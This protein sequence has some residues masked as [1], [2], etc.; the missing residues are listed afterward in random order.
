MKY[1]ISTITFLFIC[2]IFGSCK[3]DYIRYT[4]IDVRTPA[5]LTLDYKAKNVLLVDNSPASMDS[6]GQDT[7]YLIMPDTARLFILGSLHDYINNEEVFDSVRFYTMNLNGGHNVE[8]LSP[9]QIQ[10]LC[11]ESKSDI[12]ISFDLI[13]LLIP[14]G[15]EYLTRKHQPPIKGYT[16]AVV[17]IYRKDG[18]PIHKTFFFTHT[19]WGIQT[20]TWRDM[21]NNI[22]NR[23]GLL[24]HELS[25]WSDKMT[26][27][28]VP[29]WSREERIYY[30][31]QKEY[32]KT[33]T[34]HAQKGEWLEAA[35]IW[36]Q[37]YETEKKTAEKVRLAANIA[38]ANEYLDDLEYAKEWIT[39]AHSLLEE[40]DD[41]YLAN[42]VRMYK[43]Q[44]ERRMVK[45]SE[46]KEQLQLI[47][48]TE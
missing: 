13:G 15:K 32:F 5:E 28:L 1:I 34:Q 33:A 25:R 3:T 29:C 8:F 14:R 22:Y 35:D 38:L 23:K 17:N 4:Y 41:S 2:F 39:I 44:L 46:V 12:L 24:S 11:R 27:L 18:T 21:E 20:S 26:R 10:R 9:T 42:N 48:G 7:T 40:K 31:S 37:L 36:G 30:A 19:I 6:K 45:A 16:N 43:T 47:L